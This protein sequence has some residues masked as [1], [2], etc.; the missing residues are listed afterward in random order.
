MSAIRITVQLNCLVRRDNDRS[1]FVSWCPSL[2]TYSQG[3][4]EE[5]AQEAIRSAIIL[6]LKAAYAHDRLEQTLR[7]AGFT[8][9]SDA[10]G[11]EA[12]EFLAEEFVAVQTP[13]TKSYPIEV[14]LALLAQQNAGN[15]TSSS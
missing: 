1:V 11:V 14:P 6:Y 7:R 3:E 12:T 10:S 8:Q 4:T 2:D 15:R 5:E 13:E 9:L